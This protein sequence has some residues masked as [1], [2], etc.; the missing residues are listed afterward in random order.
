[1]V[2]KH[3]ITDPHTRY[4]T[5]PEHFDFLP[6]EDTVN[7]CNLR[8]LPVYTGI[9]CFHYNGRPFQNNGFLIILYIGKFF[10]GVTIPFE[11]QLSNTGTVRYGVLIFF[12]YIV[13]VF[14]VCIKSSMYLFYI[15]EQFRFFR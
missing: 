4:A 15:N 9:Q 6:L 10:Y 11:M 3:R 14:I 2:K 8:D 1:V 5:F 7:C 12:F 13:A